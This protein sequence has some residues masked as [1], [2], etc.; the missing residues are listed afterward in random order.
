MLC[1][2]ISTAGSIWAFLTCCKPSL[3]SQTDLKTKKEAFYTGYLPIPIYL[4]M[5]VVAWKSVGVKIFQ[6]M[7]TFRPTK[8]INSQYIKQKQWG[9]KQNSE[10]TL[11][12]SGKIVVH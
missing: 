7:A 11:K 5:E 1:S 6:Q 3:G 10:S 4:K 9:G 12:N 8:S 2:F